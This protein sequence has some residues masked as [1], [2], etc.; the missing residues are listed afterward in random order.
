MLPGRRA[1]SFRRDR[2]ESL[3]WQRWLQKHSQKLV[4]CGIPHIVLED[5]SH[6]YYFLEH[7]YFTPPHSPEPI[8]D[9]DRMSKTDAERVCLFLEQDDLYPQ[10]AALNRLQYLLKRGRHAENSV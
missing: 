9:V 1:M 2:E 4:A 5:M 8:I 10:S 6:W 3:Q 7:G